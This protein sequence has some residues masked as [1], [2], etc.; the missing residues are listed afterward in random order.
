MLQKIFVSLRYDN[1]QYKWILKDQV[2]AYIN[3]ISSHLLRLTLIL[4][5]DVFTMRFKDSLDY[6]R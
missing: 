5:W 4:S 1:L 6:Y 2:E 3:R